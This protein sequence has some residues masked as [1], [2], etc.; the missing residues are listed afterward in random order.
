ML[1]NKIKFVQNLKNVTFI[2]EK[3]S[4]SASGAVTGY[5]RYLSLGSGSGII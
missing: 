1:T 5:I 3:I 4:V 2:L